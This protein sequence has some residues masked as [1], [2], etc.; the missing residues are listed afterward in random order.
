MMAHDEARMGGGS[1]KS[2]GILCAGL[3][4][5]DVMRNGI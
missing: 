4:L 2:L 5:R 1:G 3:L